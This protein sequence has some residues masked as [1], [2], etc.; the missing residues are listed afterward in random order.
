MLHLEQRVSDIVKLMRSGR[1]A[2]VSH[3]MKG[4]ECHVRMWGLI[5]WAGGA[6]EGS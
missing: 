1:L 2:G 4:L 6:I 3:E 5:C